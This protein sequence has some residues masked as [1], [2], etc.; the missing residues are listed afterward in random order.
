MNKSQNKKI[1]EFFRLDEYHT[2]SS[3]AIGVLVDDMIVWGVLVEK[4]ISEIQTD[5]ASYFLSPIFR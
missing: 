2:L 4:R 3:D 5:Y 1:I